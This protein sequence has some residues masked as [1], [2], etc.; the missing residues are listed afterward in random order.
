MEPRTLTLLISTAQM[1]TLTALCDSTIQRHSAFL[2]LN[3]PNSS[4]D[5]QPRED[6]LLAEPLWNVGVREVLKE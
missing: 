5:K 6:Y 3:S 4:G 2:F 1:E